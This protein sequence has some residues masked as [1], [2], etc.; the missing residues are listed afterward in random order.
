MC[1]R[2]LK[3]LVIIYWLSLLQSG[4][5]VTEFLCGMFLTVLSVPN[6][7][8]NKYDINCIFE[9]LM[10]MRTLYDTYQCAYIFKHLTLKYPLLVSD[11]DQG[12]S[13]CAFT[14]CAFFFCFQA[15]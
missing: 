1:S 5:Y 2:S 14:D 6:I 7:L 10:H 11:Y 13:T 3:F 8:S 4:H 9:E 15:I 12:S